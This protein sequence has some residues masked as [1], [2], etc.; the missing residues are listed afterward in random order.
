MVRSRAICA[1]PLSG[2]G[3]YAELFNTGA[4]VFDG[5]VVDT[6]SATVVNGVANGGGVFI[7]AFDSTD[8]SLS[9]NVIRNNVSAATGNLSGV[10]P[11]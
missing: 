8:A 1:R 10:D 11:P 9:N 7:E 4:L 6:N 2:G 5:N 3:F